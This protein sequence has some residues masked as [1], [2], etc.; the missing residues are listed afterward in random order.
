MKGYDKDDYIPI[1]ETELD[2]ALFAHMTGAKA[3]FENGSIT[4]THISGVLPDY[5]KAMGYNRGYKLTAQDYAEIEISCRGYL[6][7][8]SG[9]KLRVAGLIERNRG[10]I[11]SGST[12]E[13]EVPPVR[14][15]FGAQS[16]GEAI[17]RKVPENETQD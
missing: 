2:K 1:D 10:G 16:L 7:V 13:I 5:H 9:A 17:K 3:V 12:P 15:F 11:G 8:I 14:K 4:G 6:G